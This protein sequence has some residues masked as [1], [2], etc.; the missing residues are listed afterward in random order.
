MSKSNPEAITAP[1]AETLEFFNGI[2]Q[3]DIQSFLDLT[4]YIYVINQNQEVYCMPLHEV[5]ISNSTIQ[6]FGSQNKLTVLC[7]ALT[8]TEMYYMGYII[9]GDP[10]EDIERLIK[11]HYALP[12]ETQKA[13]VQKMLLSLT[14]LNAAG[15]RRRGQIH[16]KNKFENN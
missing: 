3:S 4:Q 14:K 16:T 12:P 7:P 5:E 15:Q 6:M 13:K 10:R 8:S 1:L 11:N 9:T 2:N